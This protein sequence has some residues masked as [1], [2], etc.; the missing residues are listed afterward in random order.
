[1]IR[2]LVDASTFP[3]PW[4]K[5]R[6]LDAK[7]RRDPRQPIERGRLHAGLDIGNGSPRQAGQARQRTLY[8]L[9]TPSSRTDLPANFRIE[10]M[11]IHTAAPR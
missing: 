11:L 10:G 4:Q 1:V 8:Q 2:E 5:V 6:R 3:W 7:R 9:C